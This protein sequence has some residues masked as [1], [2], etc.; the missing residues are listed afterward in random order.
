MLFR[1]LAG[2]LVSLSIISTAGAGESGWSAPDGWTITDKLTASGGCGARLGGEEVDTL[3]MTNRRGQ[4][5]LAAGRP[6]WDI[7]PGEVQIGLQIGEAAPKVVKVGKLKNIIFVLMDSDERE[8]ELMS[9]HQLRWYF[10]SGLLTASVPHIGE[11]VNA[12][13]ACQAAQSGR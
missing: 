13:K 2:A 6:E 9:A 8:R 4:L 7:P 1:L 12:L 11:A 5:L 3:L 10:V